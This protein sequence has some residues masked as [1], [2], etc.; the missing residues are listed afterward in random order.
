MSCLFVSLA[1]ELRRVG[2]AKDS[3]DAVRQK[4]CNVLATG[5]SMTDPR[6]DSIVDHL[7]WD[8]LTLD[9]YVAGMRQQS[10]W[11]GGTEIGVFAELYGVRVRVRTERD[12]DQGHPTCAWHEPHTRRAEDRA[13]LPELRIRWNGGHYE[14]D[15]AD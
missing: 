15:P 2:L 5:A 11:G 9:A 10:E 1:A 13:R 8:A 12:K 7:R 3:A 6:D 4:V 14:P